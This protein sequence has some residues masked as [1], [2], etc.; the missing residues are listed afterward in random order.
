LASDAE[1]TAVRVHQYRSQ[2]VHAPPIVAVGSTQLAGHRQSWIEPLLAVQV[3]PGALVAWYAPAL[4]SFATGQQG[5]VVVADDQGVARVRFQAG[6]DP[7]VYQ[8]TA[9]S[10]SCSGQTHFQIDVE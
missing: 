1:L 7:G 4:G 2:D 10:P 5:I 6:R 8:V 3:A 9:M